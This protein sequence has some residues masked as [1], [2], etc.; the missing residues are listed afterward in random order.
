MTTSGY[1]A[2]HVRITEELRKRL[3]GKYGHGELSEKV[4]EYLES[5]VDSGFVKDPEPKVEKQK[6]TESGD[7]PACGNPDMHRR[8]LCNCERGG[9]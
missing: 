8:K 3:R 4:R 2:L 7:G 6:K 1:V 9:K 5:L